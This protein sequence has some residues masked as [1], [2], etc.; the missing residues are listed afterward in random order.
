AQ[1]KEAPQ[2]DPWVK[3]DQRSIDVLNGVDVW[4]IKGL[5]REEARNIMEYYAKSGMLR[6]TVN[7]NLVAEKWTLSGG[8]IIGELEKGTVKTRI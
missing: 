7:D 1:K 5:S 2:W 8:G 3:V 4:Q 6:Q